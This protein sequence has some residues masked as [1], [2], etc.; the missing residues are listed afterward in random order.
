MTGLITIVLVGILAVWWSI[1]LSFIGA[2]ILYGS[3]YL[4]KI[5]LCIMSKRDYGFLL[6]IEACIAL[7]VVANVQLIY[8][9]VICIFSIFLFLCTFQ[10]FYR[11]DSDFL[12]GRKIEG[13]YIYPQ[14]KWREGGT[15]KIS[16]EKKDCSLYHNSQCKYYPFRKECF[17]GYSYNKDVEKFISE[18]QSVLIGSD[19]TNP[20]NI[21]GYHVSHTESYLCAFYDEITEV[22]GLQF[23]NKCM[24]I[25]AKIINEFVIVEYT[26]RGGT[27]YSL[28]INSGNN[29]IDMDFG[30]SQLNDT[31]FLKMAISFASAWNCSL[32]Y[33]CL[34]MN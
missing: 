33:S 24:T 6:L 27:W 7:G 34:N 18:L 31:A 29:S 23:K 28:K 15:V 22:C 1:K 4:L 13:V 20:I 26:L 11:L 25:P 2:L 5:M 12:Q 10:L 30:H 17:N 14:P 3:F 19:F 9:I 32:K 16:S 8:G 21:R